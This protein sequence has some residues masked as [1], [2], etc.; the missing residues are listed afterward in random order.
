MPETRLTSE[1]NPS[2][3]HVTFMLLAPLRRTCMGLVKVIGTL[4][5]GKDESLVRVKGNE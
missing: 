2:E 1:D 5:L 3:R 4:I